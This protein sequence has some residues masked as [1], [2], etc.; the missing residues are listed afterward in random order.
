ME[1]SKIRYINVEMCPSVLESDQISWAAK[2]IYMCL[3]I[4]DWS[5]TGLSVFAKDEEETLLNGI[6]ELEEHGYIK[7]VETEH[8]GTNRKQYIPINPTTVEAYE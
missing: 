3:S 2:G 1:S 5:T 4:Y 6:K 7:Y 8:T